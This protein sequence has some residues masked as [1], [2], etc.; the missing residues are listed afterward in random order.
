MGSGITA[1]TLLLLLCSQQPRP[2]S[3]SEPSRLSDELLP[4]VS[5]HGGGDPGSQ[6]P[7]AHCEHLITYL[8]SV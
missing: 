2:A 7:S 6:G 4:S 8:L 3:H 5:V 1:S